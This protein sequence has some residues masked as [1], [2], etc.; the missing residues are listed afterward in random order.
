MMRQQQNE[1]TRQWEEKQ[2][3]EERKRKAM[4]AAMQR[5]IEETKE[6]E[7][8]QKIGA[9]PPPEIKI[10]S[11]EAHNLFI[12]KLTNPFTPIEELRDMFMQPVPPEVGMIQMTISRNK[13]GF[14]RF[15]PKY[16]LV[17]SDG[18]KFMLNA[19]KRSGN[20][21]SNYMVTLD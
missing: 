1:E 14:N 19:K 21:T 13:S 9:R 2:I 7:E 16:T 10:D 4:Q 8:A 15:Y 12:Q 5:K 6:E 11:K 17:L 18:K 20:A 3:N